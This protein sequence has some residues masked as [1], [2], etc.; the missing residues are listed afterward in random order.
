MFND[1]VKMIFGN[2]FTINEEDMDLSLLNES[3]NTFLN[4]AVFKHSTHIEDLILTQPNGA[5]IALEGL[6]HVVETLGQSSNVAEVT[7]KVD[8]APAIVFGY[9]GDRF[10]VGSKSIFNKEPKINY[11]PEDVDKNHQGDLGKV[12]KNALVY[13]KK[14]CPKGRVFQGDYVFD[15][16]SRKS[17]NID[18][19]KYYTFQPNTIKYAVEVDSDLGNA[20]GSAKFGIAVHTEYKSKGLEPQ[21][22]YVDNFDVQEGDFSK[23]PDVWLTDVNHR[24]VSKIV[25]FQGKEQKDLEKLFKT[26]E[27]LSKKI[28]VS[29][30]ME[31]SEY[32]LPFVNTYI[33]NNRP[34]PTSK[35][36]EKEFRDYINDKIKKDV[37]S[38]KTEAGKQKV[39]AK[40]ADVIKA[41]DKVK[42]LDSLFE[43]H[44]TLTKIKLLLIHKLESIKALKTFLTK[45][46][47]SLEVTGSEGYVIAQT[48]AKSCKLVDRYQ[49]SKANFS[50]D[51]TKG[52][53]H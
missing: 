5:E 9:L 14:V 30:V 29:R 45:A 37:D 47:G 52:W 24:D 2:T 32:L 50:S 18:G 11:T 16:S 15:S 21:D 3:M 20:I 7:K 48:S 51:Y 27:S 28:D 8:G 26:V 13:L 1:L 31:L 39:V 22:L 12:L 46:D 49:F 44:K 33:R 6:K 43:C 10:F 41:L 38:K 23:S 35:N 17:E 19:V 4:E 25:P 40:Y 53:E 36:M 34:Y 42:N